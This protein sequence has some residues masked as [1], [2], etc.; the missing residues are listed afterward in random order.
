[1]VIARVYEAESKNDSFRSKPPQLAHRVKHEENLNS[2]HRNKRYWYCLI[3]YGYKSIK[4]LHRHTQTQ[5][6]HVIFSYE[7]MRLGSHILIPLKWT[8]KDNSMAEHLWPLFSNGQYFSIFQL[9]CSARRVRLRTQSIFF[10]SCMDFCFCHWLDVNARCN[11]IKYEFDL[12]PYEFTEMA[13]PLCVCVGYKVR[14]RYLEVL[15]ECI[16]LIYSMGPI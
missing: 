15:C 13:K 7:R 10:E 3:D 11:I 16:Q 1:M 4:W 12:W 8:Q 5:R 2:L 14:M 6:S 9:F